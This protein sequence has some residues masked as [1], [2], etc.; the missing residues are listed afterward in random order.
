MELLTRAECGLRTP[1]CHTELPTRDIKGIAI[2]YTAAYSDEFGDAKARWRA[3]QAFHMSPAAGGG[4]G[5]W[6]DVAYNFGFRDDLVLTGRG[7]NRRS[8]G[9]GTNEGNDH[10]IAFCYLGTDKLGRRDISPLEVKTMTQFISLAEDH[11][12]K[13]L[14]VKPHSAFHSTE[15]PGDELRAVINLAPWKGS[16]PGGAVVYPKNWFLWAEWKLGEGRYKGQTPGDLAI[17]PD[18]LPP[19]GSP[20]FEKW[21]EL[22]E[23][24]LA[25]RNQ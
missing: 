12:R 21:Y 17:R 24:F 6:C 23:E 3:V 22:L 19:R 10:Y 1:T 14:V 13:E 11:Y 15:C 9:Q 16:H 7:W 8:A 4:E 20:V 25:R 5:P 18:G 2:H